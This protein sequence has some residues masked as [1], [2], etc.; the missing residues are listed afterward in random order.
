MATEA[1]LAVEKAAKQAKRDTLKRKSKLLWEIIR[2]T[3]GVEKLSSALQREVEYDTLTLQQ[4]ITIGV[5]VTAYEQASKDAP[6]AEPI[7]PEVIPPGQVVTRQ[8]MAQAEDGPEWRE[9]PA[10]AEAE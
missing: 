8:E 3:E 10:E 2:S 5:V 7:I 9:A 1:D 6:K 4:R